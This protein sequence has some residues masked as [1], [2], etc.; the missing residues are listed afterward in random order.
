MFDGCEFPV[1]CEKMRIVRSSPRGGLPGRQSHLGSIILRES[2]EWLPLLLR[3]FAVR[4]GVILP[5][6]DKGGIEAIALIGLVAGVSEK[7][8]PS[9]IGRIES[10]APLQTPVVTNKS[11]GPLRSPTPNHGPS[12]VP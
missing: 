1:S 10:Q 3:L 5:A 11:G 8:V 6:L 12:P 2:A 7:I 4:L 9:L